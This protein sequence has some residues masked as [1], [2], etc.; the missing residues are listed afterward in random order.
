M[1]L[2]CLCSR[3]E[4]HIPQQFPTQRFIVTYN[5]Y[6]GCQIHF[7]LF[8]FFSF[9]CVALKVKVFVADMPVGTLTAVSPAAEVT[10]QPG[11]HLF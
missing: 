2:V 5:M 1:L 4:S 7:L 10:Q 8:V 6:E 9:V 11:R 3:L